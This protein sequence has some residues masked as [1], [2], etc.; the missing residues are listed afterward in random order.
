M[1][2]IALTHEFHPKRAGI[3]VY[4]E[5]TARAARTLGWEIEVWAPSPA[6]GGEVKKGWAD[7]GFPFP[8]HPLPVAGRQDWPDLLRL[9]A[10]LHSSP[11]DWKTTILWLPEPGPQRLWMHRKWIGLPR[12][13]RLV[14]TFH[15]SELRR[16]LRS[17]WWRLPLEG[18]VAETDRIGVVSRYVSSLLAGNGVAVEDRVVL[19]PG[20]GK[21]RPFP[22]TPPPDHADGLTLFSAGRM[23][24]RKGYEHPLLALE[25]MSPEQRRRFRYRIAGPLVRPG[26]LRHLQTIATRAGIDFQYLGELGEMAMAAAMNR[27]DIFLFTSVCTGGSVEGFG[28]A[29]LEASAVGLPVLAYATGGVPDA[30]RHG[31]SG[32]LVPEGNVRALAASL[33]WLQENPAV[34]RKLAE[35]GPL[36]AAQFRWADVVRGL[37]PPETGVDAPV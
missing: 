29:A 26:Y 30:V 31:V 23:H 27:A 16:Y 28:L 17:P 32:W 2:I 1:K 11:P 13:A 12:P 9:A 19:V 35:Q 15:G 33:L 6:P 18:M 10:H 8:V 20:A 36:W 4:V 14:L 5:E 7:A 34:R 37:F 22:P 25:R 21:V 24:P 3:A